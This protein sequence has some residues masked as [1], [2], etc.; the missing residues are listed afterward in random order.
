MEASWRHA[1]AIDLRSAFATCAY[2]SCKIKLDRSFVQNLM[3]E[4]DL[5][6]V[7]VEAVANLGS[8]LGT[9]TTAEGVETKEQLRRA[10]ARQPALPLQR[11]Q[12]TIERSDFSEDCQLIPSARWA[13]RHGVYGLNRQY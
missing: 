11:R 5:S 9:H 4:D 8:A 6:A 13:C 7:M 2:R 12:G 1:R 3:A 10:H